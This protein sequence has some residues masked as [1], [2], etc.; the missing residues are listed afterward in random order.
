[1]DLDHID[2]VFAIDPH[3]AT[4]SLSWRTSSFLQRLVGNH[5]GWWQHLRRTRIGAWRLGTP[6]NPLLRGWT[7][8]HSLSKDLWY[9]LFKV[10]VQLTE[11][12]VR[13]RI[14]DFKKAQGL[15]YTFN[16]CFVDFNVWSLTVSSTAF[17]GACVCCHQILSWIVWNQPQDCV[18]LP[19]DRN[20]VLTN[21]LTHSTLLLFKFSTRDL[22][23]GWKRGREYMI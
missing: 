19:D 15:L 8:Y 11:L 22:V 9:D 13:W 18:L 7:Q 2:K 20:Y 6:K 1:M 17:T 4:D 23:H 3:F 5:E 16:L 14:I 10:W 12:T 21:L